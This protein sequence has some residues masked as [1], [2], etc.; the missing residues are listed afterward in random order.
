MLLAVNHRRRRSV[1]DFQSSH[2]GAYSRS[3]PYEAMMFS[4]PQLS[5]LP[6][7]SL[8]SSQFNSLLGI[9]SK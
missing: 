5:F 4:D 3:L 1:Y 7:F 2:L 9:T 8:F 6:R